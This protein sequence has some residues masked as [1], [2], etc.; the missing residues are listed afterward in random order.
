MLIVVVMTIPGVASDKKL[1]N[2]R[3]AN[4]VTHFDKADIIVT[5]RSQCWI[6]VVAVNDGYITHCYFTRALTICT[7]YD[8][9]F[10]ASI[11]GFLTS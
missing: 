2:S 11:K 1:E 6:R 3:D 4:F 9:N 5:L 7:P 8:Y 10:V